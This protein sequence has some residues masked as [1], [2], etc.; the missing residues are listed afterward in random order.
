MPSVT[1]AGVLASQEN[2]SVSGITPERA[3]MAAMS[4]GRNPRKPVAAASPT[5]SAMLITDP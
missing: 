5:P 1:I 4:R 2:P 3:A